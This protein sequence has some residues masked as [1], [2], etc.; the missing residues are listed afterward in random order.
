[1]RK[2]PDHVTSLVK[3]TDVFFV[4]LAVENYD[5]FTRLSTYYEQKMNRKN[6]THETFAGIALNCF[7]L[8]IY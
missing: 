4:G 5:N 1:M 7:F 2:M 3:R 8:Q 6:M